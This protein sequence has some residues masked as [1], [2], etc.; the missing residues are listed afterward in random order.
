MSIEGREEH[1]GD[2]VSLEFRPNLPTVP[3]IEGDFWTEIHEDRPNRALHLKLKIRET[4]KTDFPYITR[5]SMFSQNLTN[6]DLECSPFANA[7]DHLK[8]QQVLQKIRELD[9]RRIY[10]ESNDSE[11]I[12][13][14]SCPTLIAGVNRERRKLIALIAELEL[15][16]KTQLTVP[17]NF[18]ERTLNSII[19]L[20]EKINSV[21]NI[22][23]DQID[24][25]VKEYENIIFNPK[26]TLINV[27]LANGNGFVR[28]LIIHQSGWIKYTKLGFKPTD[29]K[30]AYEWHQ[31]VK[32]QGAIKI[33]TNIRQY[34]S[35]EFFNSLLENSKSDEFFK[36]LFEL[37]EIN[38]NLNLLFKSSVD[39]DFNEP[40]GS[41][42]VITVRINQVDEDWNRMESLYKSND[43]LNLVPILEKFGNDD[44]TLAYGYVL[45]GQYQEAVELANSIIK[46]E[47]K[48]VAH[49]TKGLAYV[50][51]GDYKKAYEAYLL[52]VNAC[53]YEWYPQAGENL[54]EFIE[55]HKISFTDELADLERLLSIKRK[56]L[57]PNKRCYCGS[58]K[59]FK[60]CHANV[61]NFN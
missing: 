10:I 25:Y 26:T 24:D 45:K 57:S 39:I 51:L 8:L 17:L 61:T 40:T 44:T 3:F 34:S 43:Y 4:V 23:D 36:S 9:Y 55:K 14:A 32:R 27:E 54:L 58:K 46:Q 33:T 56:P 21:T 16:L 53:G 28:N 12:I 48:S 59:S 7:N 5:L 1:V 42:Q 30:K 13:T 19:A 60:K 38:T 31:V 11:K 15:K 49:M 50:G 52:G 47:I 35:L 18:D 20:R 41:L 37:L 6:F 22:S 2:L 29:A